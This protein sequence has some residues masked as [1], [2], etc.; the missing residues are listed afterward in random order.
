MSINQVRCIQRAYNGVHRF[1]KLEKDAIWKD[2]SQAN[3]DKIKAA[4]EEHF[5]IPFDRINQQTRKREIVFPRHISMYLHARKTRYT[6]KQI[7]AL[8][9]GRDHT[10]VIHSEQAIS[11]CLTI[12]FHSNEKTEILTF[13]S[14]Y[15]F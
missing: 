1:E 8:H 2:A 6:K 14:K 15:G 12:P 3:S 4:I 7:G 10:T 11:D 5:G 13:F 9:G